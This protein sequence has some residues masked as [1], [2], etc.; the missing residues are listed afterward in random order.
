M[1]KE[2][3]IL[4]VEPQFQDAQKV[5]Q[6]LRTT[7]YRAVYKRI[8]TRNEI[9]RILPEFE[10]DVVLTEIRLQGFD[11]NFVLDTARTHSQDVPVIIL[12]DH[13]QQGDLF[14]LLEDGFWDVL[15]KSKLP[16]LEK[17]I[18]LMLRERDRKKAESQ[19]SQGLEWGVISNIFDK[20]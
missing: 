11:A 18:Y 13:V 2:I 14:V 16:Q 1:N 10:P 5:Q 20:E 7:Q 6:F 19:R 3:K 12:S 15:P 17:S 9:L 8:E 4:H